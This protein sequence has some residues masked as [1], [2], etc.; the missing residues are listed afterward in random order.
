MGKSET[1]DTVAVVEADLEMVVV[2]AI[3][4]VLLGILGADDSKTR[5]LG[6]EL[7]EVRRR[8]DGR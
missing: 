1:L 7:V 8:R 3:G 2:A 5:F 4:G 6:L